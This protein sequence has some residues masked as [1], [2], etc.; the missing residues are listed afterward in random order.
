MLI[1]S[2]VTFRAFDAA[3][4]LRT[5][6]DC[7]GETLFHELHTHILLYGESGRV[8]DLGRAETAFRILT[9]LLSPRSAP[10]SNRMLLRFCNYSIRLMVCFSCLVSSGT[11]S[12]TTEMCQG[13]SVSLVDLMARHVRA[14]LGQH[15][16]SECEEDAKHRH[17]TL[18][19]LLITVKSSLTSL[20]VLDFSTLSAIILYKFSNFGRH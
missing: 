15:F 19:E 13:F 2:I 17:F 20:I 7:E 11:A 14:I 5:S 1:L 3:E 10:I 9:S 16:W 8:V 6:V 18:L 12:Q 4:L